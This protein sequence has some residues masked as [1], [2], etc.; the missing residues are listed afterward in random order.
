MLEALILKSLCVYPE[1]YQT[2]IIEIEWFS[3]PLAEFII[4][5]AKEGKPTTP[6][7]LRL[8]GRDG[9]NILKQEDM[10]FPTFLE[11]VNK[12]K[13]AY[14]HER[15]MEL[16]LKLM[17]IDS[18]ME[19]MRLVEDFK[20]QSTKE[21]TALSFEE[22]FEKAL[23]SPN[24]FEITW[25]SIK[26]LDFSLGEVI[27]IAARP[28]VGKTAF[29][30]KIAE[31]APPSIFISLEMKR[32][33]LEARIV[34]EKTGIPVKRLLKGKVNQ[35]EIEDVR[36]CYQYVRNHPAQFIMEYTA[37]AIYSRIEQEAANGIKVFFFDYLQLAQ[38]SGRKERYLEIGE[39]SRQLNLLANALQVTIFVGSQIGREGHG[40]RPNLSMIRESGNVEQD[41]Q[42]VIGL[43]REAVFLTE[44]QRALMMEE[45]LQKC[46]VIVLKDRNGGLQTINV[47]FVNGHFQ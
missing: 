47:P 44:E 3:H 5:N 26:A 18:T 36:R 21:T 19:R 23:I 38:G 13:E 27:Y 7:Q 43:Y 15:L 4:E 32:H 1:R 16:S 34:H 41:A 11:A 17:S 31:H 6:I 45:D 12:V 28:S 24:D 25:K 30:L 29:M 37:T 14:L 20:R 46:E 10:D 39:I 8:K 40:K 22:H 33:V 9:L 42:V 35:F 2:G